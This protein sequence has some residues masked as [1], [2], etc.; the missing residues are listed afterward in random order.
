MRASIR[1][2]LLFSLFLAVLMAGISPPPSEARDPI[3]DIKEPYVAPPYIPPFVS[4]PKSK[5]RLRDNGDGTITDENSGLMWTQKDSYAALNN[6]L[7]YNQTREYVKNLRTG[8][9]A[10]WRIPTIKELN[11]IYD[12]TKQNVMSWNHDPEYPLALDEKFADGAAYWYWSADCGN[13][14]LTECC[15]RSY[16]FVN[17]LV[18]LRHF[19]QCNNGGV[20]AVR[21]IDNERKNE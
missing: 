7:N 18:D 10:D 4:P 6:C 3:C 19:D 15:A 13:T 1:F 11:G 14:L 9:Y 21:N 17:G 5:T 2:T 12:P 8:G 16:Y 20:R